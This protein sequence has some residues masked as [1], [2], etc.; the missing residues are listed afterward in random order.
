AEVLGS[1]RPFLASEE[2]ALL[3]ERSTGLGLYA[4]PV[5]PD[6][7]GALDF[8]RR[9]LGERAEGL[10][11]EQIL[12]GFRE[13]FGVPQDMTDEAVAF[14][15]ELYSRGRLGG[16]DPKVETKLPTARRM[17]GEKAAGLSD[18]DLIETFK[19]G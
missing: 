10:T 7:T 9:F 3:R 19:K 6:S 16:I 14:Q 12:S 5:G 15:A 18:H 11:D 8:S 13:K 1:N 4:N 17:L 2:E